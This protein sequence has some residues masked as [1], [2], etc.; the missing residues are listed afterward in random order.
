[1]NTNKIIYFCIPSN[2]DVN[3]QVASN[4]PQRN[5]KRR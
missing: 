5:R 4:K 1:M 3:P 2:I